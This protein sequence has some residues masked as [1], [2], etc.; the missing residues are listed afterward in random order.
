MNNQRKISI[1]NP[2]ILKWKLS[3]AVYCRVSTS[4][5]KQI[6]SLSNQIDYYK[7]MVSHNITWNLVD[8]YVDTKSGRNT[9]DRP[10]FQ[11]MLNDCINNKIDLIIKKSISLLDVILLILLL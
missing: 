8:I 9:S 1:I 11:R 2:H 6:E 10:E 4:H 5:T 3:V 7:N